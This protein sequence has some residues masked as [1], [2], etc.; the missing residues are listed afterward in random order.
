MAI[1]YAGIKIIGRKD[2]RSAVACAAYRSGDCLEDERQ[3]KVQHYEQRSGVLAQ[4]ILL[5]ANAP[6]WMRDREQLWNAVERREDRSTRPDEAQ[7]AREFVIALPH[8]LDDPAREYLVKNIIKEAATRKGM[9][10]DY[11]IHTPDKEGD[12][13]NYHAHIM[14]TLRGI[15]P[16]DPDGFGNKERAWNSKQEL[17]AF[18]NTIERETNKMLKRHGIEETISFDL[19]EGKKPQRHMGE[20]ATKL[21]RKGIK[22][23]VGNENR[24]AAEHNR[25]LGKT[26]AQFE[27]LAEKISHVQLRTI[28]EIYRAEHSQQRKDTAALVRETWAKSEKDGLG[29]MAALGE[30]GLQL[31]QTKKDGLVLLAEN[32]LV[33]SL[34]AKTHGEDLS[35]AMQGAI[36][37]TRQDHPDLIIPTVKE[38]IADQR[39]QIGESIERALKERQQQERQQTEA[40]QK[41]EQTDRAAYL[42]HREDMRKRMKALAEEIRENQK[43]KRPKRTNASRYN[44]GSMA[45]QQGDAVRQMTGQHRQARRK[46]QQEDIRRILDELKQERQAKA[47]AKFDKRQKDERDRVEVRQYFDRKRAGV[48]DPTHDKAARRILTARA[49]NKARFELTRSPEQKRQAKEEREKREIELFKQRRQAG[50]VDPRRDKAALALM[51]KQEQQEAATPATQR[52]EQQRRDQEQQQKQSPAPSQAGTGNKETTDK[53]RERKETLDRFRKMGREVERENNS[54]QRDRGGGG[55][56]RER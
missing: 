13:R 30:N 47:Q 25:E 3:G 35:A 16:K 27:Q 23:E 42:A 54:Q 1:A 32:G 24:A 48:K 20:S 40:A 4:G 15:D 56:I 8:E 39:A 51:T 18:K 29:F 6:E 49:F 14:L 34:N 10:A 46:E 38:R 41:Q 31:A 5:P 26:R 2:G 55:R 52:E 17:R 43:P 9:V 11:A 7:L 12:N 21:E 28:E 37:K 33:H 53:E 44:H 19:E 22:T 45:S 36:A 50:L